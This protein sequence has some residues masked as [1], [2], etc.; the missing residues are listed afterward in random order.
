MKNVDRP[1]QNAPIRSFESP[2]VVEVVFGVH[3]AALPSLQT[4]HYG[5]FWE[6]IRDHYPECQ[7]HPPLTPVFERFDKKGSPKFEF[8]NVPPLRRT[9]FVHHEKTSIIQMQRDRF[10]CNWRKVN[11]DDEYPRYAS[12][13]EPFDRNL[14]AFSGFASEYDLGKLEHQQY[15]LTYVNR[16]HQS[17][18]WQ[19]PADLG[20][21]FPDFHWRENEQRFLPAPER[22]NWVTTFQL[23]EQSGRLHVSIRTAAVQEG[24]QELF[25]ELTARGFP[26]SGQRNMRD[27]FDQAHQ[28]I[29]LGF[30]D[31]TD[32]SVRKNT[33]RQQ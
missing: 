22:V 5:A 31:L 28:W 25:L 9:W 3:F 24:E 20:S 1:D 2:P 10:L 26:Q 16:I 15:E 7:D 33:W 32:A 23:P 19:T 11:P 14:E 13:I 30:E 6:R 18:G 4:A 8:S 17:D 21:V 27:W 29:V 12:L